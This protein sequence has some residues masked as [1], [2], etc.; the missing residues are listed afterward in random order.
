[1]VNEDEILQTLKKYDYFLNNHTIP[2][3]SDHLTHKCDMVLGYVVLETCLKGLV[4]LHFGYRGRL[5]LLNKCFT[6][7]QLFNHNKCLKHYHEIS[8]PL[9]LRVWQGKNSSKCKS[10]TTSLQHS[11]TEADSEMPTQI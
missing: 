4:P 10:N 7:P 1:M 6:F 11:V 5:N 9:M 3:T 8:S 2:I